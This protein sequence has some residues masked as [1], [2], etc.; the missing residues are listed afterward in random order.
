MYTSSK[1]AYGI[2]LYLK[3]KHTKEIY[4]SPKRAWHR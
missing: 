4:T 1:R 3:I 2:E